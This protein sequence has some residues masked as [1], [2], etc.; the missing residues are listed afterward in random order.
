MPPFGKGNYKQLAEERQKE[1]TKL[2]SLERQYTNRLGEMARLC[3]IVC[4][5]AFQ[6]ISL[7]AEPAVK[8]AVDEIMEY[9][10][11]VRP[12]DGDEDTWVVHII[13][14]DDVL[15][16]VSYYEGMRRANQINY[17]IAENREDGDPFIIAI[18][19]RQPL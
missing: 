1:I 7:D 5:W 8:S 13:G 10:E 3:D 4:R 12:T 19:V 17:Q 11:L 6:Q 14:Q 18:V 2:R 15:P 9:V 16:C